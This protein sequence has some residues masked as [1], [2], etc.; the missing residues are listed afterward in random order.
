MAREHFLISAWDEENQT[1]TYT[2]KGRPDLAPVVFDA[3]KYPDMHVCAILHGFDQKL[4]DKVAGELAK[5]GQD[6]FA[7]LFRGTVVDHEVNFAAGDWNSRAEGGGTPGGGLHVRAYAAVFGKTLEAVK[8]GWAK[9][10][11]PQKASIRKD[12]RISDWVKVEQARLDAIKP[13]IEVADLESL[14]V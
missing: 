7:S 4:R 3:K 13:K 12:A 2:F 5:L 14:I 9:L 8:E 6:G 1:L 11:A 10:T